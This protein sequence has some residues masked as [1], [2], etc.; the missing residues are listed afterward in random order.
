MTEE[1]NVGCF[2][3]IPICYRILVLSISIDCN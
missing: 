3:N 2:Q 1:S